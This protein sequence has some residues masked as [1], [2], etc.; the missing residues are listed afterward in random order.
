MGDVVLITGVAGHLGGRVARALSHDPAVERVVGVDTLV[1]SYRVGPTE[2]VRADVRDPVIS[3]VISGSGV[4][5]VVHAHLAPIPPSRRA[6]VVV[7]ETNVIGT[8]KLL[9]ACQKS[10]SVRRVVVA[11]TSA[12]YGASP[13][14][15]ALFTE[16]TG[17]KELPSEG[18]GKDALEMEG[19]VRAFSRRCPGTEVVTLR[20]ADLV[21]PRVR[22]PVVDHLTLPVVPTVLGF[23]PRLQFLHE[24]DAVEAVRQA[25]VGRATGTL[26]VAGEGVV[27]LSQVLRMLGRPWAPV[28]LH[29]AGLV[30]QALRRTGVGGLPPSQIRLLCHGRGMDTARLRGLLGWEPKWT[31]RDA[32]ADLAET[33]DRRGP[34]SPEA[35][36]RVE[37][38]LLDLLSRWSGRREDA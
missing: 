29:L 25:V 31:T 6:A 19:Y 26:N 22:N 14:D 13:R 34:L 1:P 18:W 32:V 23:D 5:V 27:L 36:R 30:D 38:H 7:R 15:P 3:R 24:D 21:G 20:L 35:A 8:M 11:S 37:G 9:A 12:V 2:F 33:L 16:D 4:R 10:P 28:P 17:A